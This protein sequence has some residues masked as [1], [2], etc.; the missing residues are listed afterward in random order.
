MIIIFIYPEF[1]FSKTSLLSNHKQNTD[2]NKI[3]GYSRM[4]KKF[5]CKAVFCS[6]GIFWT[7]SWSVISA[8]AETSCSSI[9][10]SELFSSNFIS[11]SSIFILS[12][13]K[14]N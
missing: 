9:A 13:S 2:T 14:N 1:I 8:W 10:F 4:Q 11:I 3:S 7:E 6:L 5:T 12:L